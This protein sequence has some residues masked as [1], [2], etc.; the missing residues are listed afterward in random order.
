MVLL[1]EMAEMVFAFIGVIWTILIVANLIK[2]RPEENICTE[3]YYIGAIRLTSKKDNAVVTI[4]NL[5]MK[6]LPDGRSKREYVARPVD[7]WEKIFSGSSFKMELDAWQEGGKFP[8]KFHPVEPLGEM[9]NRM[10]K[11]KL[12]V[13]DA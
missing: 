10:M 4:I 9:L 3:Q 13:A 12:G 1:V 8:D 7:G 2:K 6:E 11:K 5:Y